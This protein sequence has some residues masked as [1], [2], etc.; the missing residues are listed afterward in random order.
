MSRTMINGLI[1]LI[2]TGSWTLSAQANDQSTAGDLSTT[3]LTGTSMSSAAASEHPRLLRLRQQMRKHSQGQ[4]MARVD[5]FSQLSS[6]PV[7]AAIMQLAAIERSLHKQ[8]AGDQAV[9]LYQGVLE[10]EDHPS[11]RNAA[12]LRLSQIAARQDDHEQSMAWLQ[13]ALEENLDRIP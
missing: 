5:Q 10:R 6:D 1:A 9:A 2:V 3:A 4:R 8:G 7:N 13:Q 11:L 12:Y